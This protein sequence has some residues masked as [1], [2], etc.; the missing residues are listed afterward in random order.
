V[1]LNQKRDED[2]IVSVS[3]LKDLQDATM[4][5]S[6]KGRKGSNKN[7]VSLDI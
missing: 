7:V 5:R 2:S 6:G 1:D 4:P 3:S